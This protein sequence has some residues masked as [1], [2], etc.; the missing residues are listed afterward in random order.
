MLKKE[1]KLQASCVKYIQPYFSNCICCSQ[2]SRKVRWAVTVAGGQIQQQQPYTCLHCGRKINPAEEEKTGPGVNEDFPILDE[3]EFYKLFDVLEEGKT[4]LTTLEVEHGPSEWRDQSKAGRRYHLASIDLYKSSLAN[5]TKIPA[6]EL[7]KALFE[8]LC[9][10]SETLNGDYLYIAL[11]RSTPQLISIVRSI[12]VYGFEKV[13]TEEQIK[14]T[15]N[16][17]II[18]FKMELHQD[19]DYVELD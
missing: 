1:S 17:D 3:G 11:S 6:K 16:A 9:K 4:T 7:T 10:M 12:L 2:T 19:T 13:S 15:S 5:L 8:D 14:F 18:M